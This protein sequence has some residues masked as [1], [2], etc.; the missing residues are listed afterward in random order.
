MIE[1]VLIGLMVGWLL[2][3]L[4]LPF[5]VDRLLKPWLMGRWKT[6]NKEIRKFVPCPECGSK[7]KHKKS[8]SHYGVKA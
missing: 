2:G 4:T 3:V 1:E 6:T 8:C 5:I 7:S